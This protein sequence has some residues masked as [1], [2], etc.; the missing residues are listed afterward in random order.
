MW[1][2]DE[3]KILTLGDGWVWIFSVIDHWNAERLGWHVYKT[4]KGKKCK[5]MSK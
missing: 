2:S 3:P 1:G 5:F 4:A